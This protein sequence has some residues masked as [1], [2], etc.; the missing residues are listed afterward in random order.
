MTLGTVEY[1]RAW[2]L[3]TDLVAGDPRRATTQHLAS[4]G[5]SSRLHPGPTFKAR[6]PGGTRHRCGGDRPGRPGNLPRPW[7]VSRLPHS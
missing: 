7:P 1:R 6:A 2:N 3:Q 5:T 4:A